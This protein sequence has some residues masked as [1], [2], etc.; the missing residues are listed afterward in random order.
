MCTSVILV[1][2]S[3][4][5]A[6]SAKARYAREIAGGIAFP[7][8]STATVHHSLI[9]SC[10]PSRDGSRGASRDPLEHSEDAGGHMTKLSLGQ[11]ARL[12]GRG[13]TILARAISGRLFRAVRKAAVIR[14]NRVTYAASASGFTSPLASFVSRT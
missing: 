2:A 6:R 14:L 11:A 5:P 12:T 8:G 13:K 4:L 10:A 1:I 3:R 9:N 7:R